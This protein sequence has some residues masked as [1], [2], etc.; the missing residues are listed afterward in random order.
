MPLP[1]R[2]LPRRLR[3]LSLSLVLLA[4]PALAGWR[5]VPYAD[6]AKMPLGL[7]AVDPGHVFSYRYRVQPG[8]G[9]T[10]LPA[11]LQLRVRAGGA[12]HP[13]V[14]GADN[15][16]DVPIRQDWADGGA[17]LQLN[18]PKGRVN[19]SLVF[20]ARTPPGTRMRYG[21]LAESGPVLERGIRAMAGM[22]SFLAPKVRSFDLRFDAPGPQTLSLTPPGGRPKLWKT[23]AKGVLNLP[24]NAAWSNAEVVL[25]APLKALDPVMK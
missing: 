18:Q 21:Q 3:A 14:V 6:V 25:S 23:D 8:K 17:V 15:R 22:M 2:R 19:L 7:A 4:G 5:D 16:V 11:D 20:D 24:W 9:E 12:F 13:L 1:D 10:T